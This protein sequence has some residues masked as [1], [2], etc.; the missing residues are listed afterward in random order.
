MRRVGAR[1]IFFRAFRVWLSFVLPFFVAFFVKLVSYCPLLLLY[2]RLYFPLCIY[3]ACWVIFSSILRLSK[4][5]VV[6][7]CFSHHLKKAS[8]L[9][10]DCKKKAKKKTKNKKAE[11]KTELSDWACI[12]SQWCKNLCRFRPPLPLFFI[13]Q[14]TLKLLWLQAVSPK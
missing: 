13:S 11:K 5:V 3:L 4:A 12:I 2:V 7:A 10:W 6:T 1:I 9:R 8:S 14:N